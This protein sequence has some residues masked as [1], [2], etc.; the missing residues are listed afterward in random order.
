MYWWRFSA[1]GLPFPSEKELSELDM[2][3]WTTVGCRAVEKL[4][5]GMQYL[6][7]KYYGYCT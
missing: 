6:V 3:G 5:W 2:R 4:L 1:T 7:E